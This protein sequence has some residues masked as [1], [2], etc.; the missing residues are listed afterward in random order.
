VIL[1]SNGAMV[2]FGGFSP[3]IDYSEPATI[4]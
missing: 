3:F 4:N 2:D 1:L